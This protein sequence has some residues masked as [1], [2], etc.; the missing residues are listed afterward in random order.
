[1]EGPA[2]LFSL[3]FFSRQKR[4]EVFFAIKKT[5]Y[6]IGKVFLLVENFFVRHEQVAFFTYLFTNLLANFSSFFLRCLF[7]ICFYN[8]VML[9]FYLVLLNEIFS[10]KDYLQIYVSLLYIPFIVYS[11]ATFLEQFLPPTIVIPRIFYGFLDGLSDLWYGPKEIPASQLSTQVNYFDHSPN[12]SNPPPRKI[13][14]LPRLSDS[15]TKRFAAIL[16]LTGSVYL[17]TMSYLGLIEA[18]NLEIRATELENYKKRIYSHLE[19]YRSD[20]KCSSSFYQNKFSQAQNDYEKALIDL[21]STNPKEVL[22]KK[23][24]LSASLSKDLNEIYGGA[25][26]AFE[27]RPRLW[28]RKK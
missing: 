5:F 3:V 26:Q 6:K 12:N 7:F 22:Q 15:Y 16:V 13:I 10:I 4:E 1:M 25:L 18:K 9:I 2:F 28:H 19:N 20:P 23:M 21:P 27:E 14:R 11:R 24:E 8:P 17:G